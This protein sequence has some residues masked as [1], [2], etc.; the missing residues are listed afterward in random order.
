MSG[1]RGASLRRRYI[2]CRND[3][4]SVLTSAEGAGEIRGWGWWGVCRFDSVS[5]KTSVK[6][7]SFRL[8]HVVFQPH[9][10]HRFL[11]KMP[12]VCTKH[13]ALQTGSATTV[14]H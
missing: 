7:Q 6:K 4:Q 10:T 14:I 8:E 1:C 13:E 3:R 12:L 11:F 2:C 5:V 9:P